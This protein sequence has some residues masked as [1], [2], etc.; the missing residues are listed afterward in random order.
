MRSKL[1]DDEHWTRQISVVFAHFCGRNGLSNFGRGR[2]CGTMVL[3]SCFSAFSS[4]IF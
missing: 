1:E 2:A 3:L 4:S